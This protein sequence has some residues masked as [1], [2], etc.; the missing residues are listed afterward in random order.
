MGKKTK[1][2]EV[3]QQPTFADYYLIPGNKSFL[4]YALYLRIILTVYGEIQ[5]KYYG[6]KYSD[7]D[8]SV[9]TD[10]ANYLTK[11][12]SPYDRHTYRYTP[13]LAYLMVPNVLYAHS[14]GKIAFCLCDIWTARILRSILQKS[15]ELK[16]N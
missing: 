15:T 1:K 9:Y 16:D 4:A 5:D 11:G 12:G 7:I 10:A 3:V 14:I 13:L 2:E 8:Y 6:I